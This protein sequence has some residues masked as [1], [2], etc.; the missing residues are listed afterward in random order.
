MV[1]TRKEI[2]HLKNKEQAFHEISMHTDWSN[3]RKAAERSSWKKKN[4]PDTVVKCPNRGKRHK[5]KQQSI[6]NE[7]E[8]QLLPDDPIKKKPNERRPPPDEEDDLPCFLCHQ[9]SDG[10]DFP[11]GHPICYPCFQQ[12]F[13]ENDGQ[14]TCPICKK[15]YTFHDGLVD[16]EEE[17]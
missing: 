1:L 7:P 10:Y 14:M 8:Q 17:H 13:L 15:D 12:L 4:E 2:M 6:T 16:E 11:C 5:K 9:S 3:H